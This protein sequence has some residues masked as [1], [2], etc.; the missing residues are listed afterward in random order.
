LDLQ[1]NK[2]YEPTARRGIVDSY[3]QSDA[4]RGARGTRLAGLFN[5]CNLTL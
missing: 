5:G 4:F 2:R 1:G 3:K